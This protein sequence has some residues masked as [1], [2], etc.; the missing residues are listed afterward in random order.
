MVASLGPCFDLKLPGQISTVLVSGGGAA[1]VCGGAVSSGLLGY[2]GAIMSRTFKGVDAV[3]GAV[4]WFVRG[5]LMTPGRS[6]DKI[7][8][9]IGR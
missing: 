2:D 8:M 5:D 3:H 4:Q 7:I 1:A 9:D 6:K